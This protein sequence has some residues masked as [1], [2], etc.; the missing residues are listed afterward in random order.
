MRNACFSPSGMAATSEIFLFQK[1]LNY[2]FFFFFLVVVGL[3][4]LQISSQVSL[5]VLVFKELVR[6]I[7]VEVKCIS[8]FRIFL[9]YFNFCR[10]CSDLTLIIFAIDNSVFSLSFSDSFD[11]SII[12]YIDFLKKSF[13][14]HFF[15]I[16]SQF[17]M[18]LIF[19][20]IF[21]LLLP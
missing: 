16:A 15:P 18:S 13:C 8:L 3:F 12:N 11:S 10:I 2:G 14:F 21:F 7:T 20:F 9:Y 1:A 6:F 19:L 4:G 5:V 17:S